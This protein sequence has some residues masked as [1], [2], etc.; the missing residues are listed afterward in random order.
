MYTFD[1]SQ[2]V[3][4]RGE[5]LLDVIQLWEASKPEGDYH[6]VSESLTERSLLT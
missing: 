4:A 3:F 6:N 1:F 2:R 5:G